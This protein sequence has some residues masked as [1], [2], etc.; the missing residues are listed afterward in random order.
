MVLAGIARNWVITVVTSENA[1]YR[2]KQIRAR[3]RQ[4]GVAQG[5]GGC[6]N[7][8]VGPTTEPDDNNALPQSSSKQEMTCPDMAMERP[9]VNN[10]LRGLY[11]PGFIGGTLVMRLTDTGAARSILSLK[12]YN[13]FPASVKFSLS[14]VNSAIALADGQKTHGVGHVVVHLGTKE[15]Q[16]HVVVTEVEDQGTL[17][18]DF[19]S[20]VDSHVDT[21]KSELWINGEL[22]ECCDFTNQPLSSRCV[23][24]RSTIIE[25]NAE[26]IIP[27]TVQQRC[28]NLDPKASP[29][30]MRLLKRLLEPCLNSHLRLKSIYLARTPVDVKEV[31]VV[32]LRVFNI[33]V[34]VY[35]LAAET[36]VALAKPVIDV[37]LLAPYVQNH[38]SVVGKARVIN[39]HASQR[40]FERTLPRTLTGTSRKE[41]RALDRRSN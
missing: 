3:E 13:S 8:S 11:L 31:R 23:V 18:M 5:P 38:E 10:K 34:D 12:V 22:F 32:P 26:V 36:V 39:E 19:L 14:S 9:Q 33:S 2:R 28:T 17:G 29:L 4:Q 25:P 21:V 40:T 24:R 30:S 20:Q 15:F 1:R 6:Q 16:V 41:R 37:T 27:V 35:N 7:E